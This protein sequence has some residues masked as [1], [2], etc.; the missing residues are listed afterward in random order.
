[1]VPYR[2]FALKLVKIIISL[3]MRK[4]EEYVSNK[5]R[6][7]DSFGPLGDEETSDEEDE[8]QKNTKKS[9]SNDKTNDTSEDNKLNKSDDFNLLFSGN[10]DDHFR[11]G[12]S[13]SKKSLKLFTE[14]YSSD[15]IIASPL[16]LK[17]II[18]S[19][20]YNIF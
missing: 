20:G 14:F 3:L 1:M 19:E 2:K 5:K 4:K 6:F 15:I 7:F 16:G 10:T 13:V 8:D 9:N 12:L 18:G 11:I 17:S